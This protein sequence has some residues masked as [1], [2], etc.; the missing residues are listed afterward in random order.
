M[1]QA[2]LTEAGSLG[3]LRVGTNASMRDS[4]VCARHSELLMLL[5][6]KDSRLPLSSDHILC[7]VLYQRSLHRPLLHHHVPN[8]IP[9]S[10]MHAARSAAGGSPHP[11]LYK[12]GRAWEHSQTEP[13]AACPTLPGP[14]KTSWGAGPQCGEYSLSLPHRSPAQARMQVRS[15]AGPPRGWAGPGRG[16]QHSPCSC[17]PGLASWSPSSSLP[18]PSRMSGPEA[19][20]CAGPI[21]GGECPNLAPGP[22]KGP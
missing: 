19:Q 11:G 3:L 9:E 20:T 5:W 8:G 2:G 16:R 18:A 4:S 15:W 14:R 22:G 17:P 1:C 12:A 13:G 6:V 10:G 21:F 7:W